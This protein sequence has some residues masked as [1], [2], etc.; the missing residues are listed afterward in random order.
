M[1]KQQE[2]SA[3]VNQ[4]EPRRWLILAVMSLS[5]FMLTL[6]NT[7]VN[8]ALPTMARSLQASTGEIQWIVDSYILMLAGLL[9][10]GGTI[11]DIFGRRRWFAIGMVI[12]GLASVGGALSN[13]ANQLIL[14]RGLQGVGGA[15][16]MPATLSIITNSFA[17]AERAKAI[18]IWTGVGA[19]A[20]GAGPAFGGYLVDHSGW[21]SIFWLH[22]PIVLTALVGLTVVPESR[23]LRPR[24]IDVPGAITGTLTLSALVFGVIS[25]GERGWLD[26]QVLASLGAALVLGIAFFMIESR[27]KSP[28]LPMQFF[29]EKDFTAG[30]VTVGVVFFAV[31]VVFFFLTQFYQLVQGR[32]AFEAGLL[33]LP[34][35]IAMMIGAPTSG[36]LV[37]RI[38]PKILVTAA[39]GTVA[40]A[41]GLL[42]QLTA[43]TSTLQIAAT[44]AL[45]GL[46]GGLGLAPLT[47]MVMASVPV[48]DAGIGSAMNDVSRELGAALGIAA[49]G[50][51]VSS[52]YR[53]N[54]E[55]AFTQGFP[56][57]LTDAAGEGIGVATV[58][59]G[60]L[61]PEVQATFVTLTQTAFVDAFTIGFMLSAMLLA[62]TAVFAAV[63]VPSKFRAEQMESGNTLAESPL[64]LVP[65]G[66]AAEV[67][68]V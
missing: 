32:T 59:A 67:P 37:H 55:K 66:R 1:V 3:S 44:T 61:P 23:D 52:L 50:S 26:P 30:V 54:V 49:I 27:A 2:P 10:V 28:M 8:T 36:I 35:A 40:L 9:L 14:F 64:A 34:S 12:F 68:V 63:L 38:G 51:F 31:A 56:P 29:L 4:G 42:S 21:S 25:A 20:M 16:V 15:L 53:D 7:I 6:D 5:M 33:S 19:L 17:R 18:G 47:D 11:G 58:V 62:T 22:V 13:S 46:A 45:F 57:E 65:S 60:T 48:D 39:V 43:D 24:G 41:V